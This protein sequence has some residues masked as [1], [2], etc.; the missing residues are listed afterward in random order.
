ME[1]AEVPAQP[2]AG[3]RDDHSMTQKLSF[4]VAPLTVLGALA[5]GACAQDEP[6]PMPPPVSPSPSPSPSPTAPPAVTYYEHIQPLL[7]RSCLGCHEAGGIGQPTFGTPEEASRLASLIAVAVGS[8][9]MPPYY[10]SA[11]CNTYADDP[12]FTAEELARIQQWAQLGGPLGDV[13]DA[14]HA[15]P[16][17]A[18]VV[19]PDLV[20]GL[21]EPFDAQIMMGSDNYRCFAL[22]PQLAADVKVTG[23]H[24]QPGNRAIVHHVL[25]YVV[26]PDQVA[27][28]AALDAEDPG[29]GYEC[30]SGGVGIPGA[31]QSQ[32]G[33]FVPGLAAQRM[34]SGYGL[35]IP[36]GSKIVMQV[37]YNLL[38]A[39]LGGTLDDTRL[40]LE[41]SR[42]AGLK[43]AQILPMVRRNL[44][45]AAGDPDSVQTQELPLSLMRMDSATVYSLTGHM[46]LLGTSVRLDYVRADGSTECLLHI[47]RWDF[48]WQRDYRLKTPVRLDDRRGKLRIT[49]TYDNSAANQPVVDGQMQAPRDVQ[50]GESSLDE[51]CMT[52]VLFSTE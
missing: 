9:R 20:L 21:P 18:V 36:A 4:R 12:R 27:A 39:E 22:D 10:A 23:S 37:H 5:L 2:G 38:A 52:Y 44:D 14:V 17:E 46:H 16:P 11:D 15:T 50:W 24:V 19:R 47:P 33:S 25:A 26:E 6:T 3:G 48:D 49:C 7:E 45:I 13:A 8:G 30:F 1:A 29:P 34:P 35:T 43:E 41:L 51:M 42:D 40:V 31:I 28:L 32:I